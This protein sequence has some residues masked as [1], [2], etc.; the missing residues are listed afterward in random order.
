MHAKRYLDP[1]ARVT[2]AATERRLQQSRKKRKRGEAGDFSSADVLRLTQVHV[3]GFD[4]G[5]VWEQAR[6]ILSLSNEDIEKAISERIPPTT[7]NGEPTVIPSDSPHEN[8]HN[9]PP[10]FDEEG[11]EEERRTADEASDGDEVGQGDQDE[12]ELAS[13]DDGQDHMEDEGVDIQSM[14][15]FDLN[16]EKLLGRGEDT[17]GVFIPDKNGLNDGFFSLE[18]FNK[19]SQFLE[20][21][22]ARGELNEADGSEDEE[23]DWTANPLKAPLPPNAPPSRGDN[24][25]EQGSTDDEDEDGPIFGNA[26]LDAPD[27]EQDSNIDGDD[28]MQNTNDIKYADFFAPP[29]RQV[30]KRAHRRALPKTQPPAKSLEESEV[31]IQ[32]TIAAVRRDIFEDDVAQGEPSSEDQWNAPLD[33]ERSGRSNHQRRQ[34]ALAAEIRKLEAANVA[35]R[36]WTLSGEARAADRPIN[37]LLEEDLEFER[38]GKPIPVIT[39]EVSE[40]IEALIKRRIVA[41]EF[42]EVI[43]RRPENLATGDH[44]RRGRLELDD[45]KPQQSLADIY[46]AEHLKTN[47]SAGYVDP[48]DAKLKE[49]HAAIETLWKEV[50]AKLNGLSSLHFKPK[51]PTA[52]ITVVADVPTITMEDARPSAGGDVNGTSMLAPQ[53]VYQVGQGRTRD[54]RVREVVRKGGAVIGREEMGRDE[55]RRARRREKERARK[56]GGGVDPRKASGGVVADGKESGHRT[57]TSGGKTRL[58]RDE[59]KHVA[60]TLQK[61]GVRVIGSKGEIRDVQGR[62]VK[63]GATVTSSGNRRDAGAAF[64]L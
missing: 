18:D 60:A 47:D 44:V 43:R 20:Q 37:S 5:Q 16:N 33:G 6:R 32:Q 15:N 3:E 52:T 46:E 54:D 31:D 17:A 63:D 39:N 29:A 28:A 4:M 59:A 56:K 12:A 34:A 50:S 1:L 2:S 7:G 38:A 24:D 58:K 27:S 23:I 21:L 19:Q 13:S 11:F 22:D 9:E 49:Q 26:D 55:R 14:D 25:D 42:D 41:R 64:R 40:D 8:S 62:E 48:S 10:K 35:K 30:T 45:T 51:P 36:D 57:T 61:G 53:E